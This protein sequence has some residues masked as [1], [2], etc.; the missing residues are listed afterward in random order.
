MPVDLFFSLSSLYPFLFLLLAS[1]EILNI[2]KE[3]LME[4]DAVHGYTDSG[5]SLK[6][7]CRA[8]S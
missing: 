5:L 6:E 1:F 4:K 2:S 7:G 3:S 8:H